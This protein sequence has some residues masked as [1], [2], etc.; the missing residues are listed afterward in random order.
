MQCIW[1]K[2]TKYQSSV[3]HIF[4]ESL[5]CPAEFV[6][7]NGEV[8]KRCN[9]KRLSKLDQQLVSDLE[10]LKFLAK[11]PSKRG[12]PP[13]IATHSNLLGAYLDGGPHIYINTERHSVQSPLG[14]IGPARSDSRF[15]ITNF[16]VEGNIASVTVSQDAILN[17]KKAVRGLRKIGLELICFKLGSDIA[18]CDRFDV[19]RQFVLNGKGDRYVIIFGDREYINRAWSIQQDRFGIDVV[20]FQLTRIV[21]VVDLSP[22]QNHLDHIKQI[23]GREFGTSGWSW[24]P[25]SVEKSK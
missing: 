14:N 3:E 16:N 7:S 17:S 8:C 4:P 15:A 13:R 2:R 6:L 25:V 19:A 22:S 10:M 24:V 1:C 9:T 11:I 5:G 23:C 20:M 12:Q 18:L 21:C